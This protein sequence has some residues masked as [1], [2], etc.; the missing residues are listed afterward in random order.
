MSQNSVENQD[1][2]ARKIALL[3]AMAG[4]LDMTH[5]DLKE[6]SSELLKKV[7]ERKLVLIEELLNKISSLNVIH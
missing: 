2:L 4:S 5:P 1:A 3:D 7:H 6:R